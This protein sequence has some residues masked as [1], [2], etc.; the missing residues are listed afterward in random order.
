[1]K[2]RK[3]LIK[4]TNFLENLHDHKNFAHYKKKVEDRIFNRTADVYILELD[5]K[6]IGEITVHYGE[7]SPLETISGKRVYFS[8]FRILPQYRGNGFGK[9]FLNEVMSCLRNEGY[10]E[11]TIGVEESN[12]KAAHIYNILGFNK[13]IAHLSEIYEGDFYEY[14]LLLNDGC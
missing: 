3:L 1:M 11:F 7:K 2:V 5:D 10:S 13:V 8:A 14:K 9:L 6:I 12:E 4:E